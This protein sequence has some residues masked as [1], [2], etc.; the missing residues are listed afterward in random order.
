M[1]KKGGREVDKRWALWVICLLILPSFFFDEKHKYIEEKTT[2]ELKINK[3]R[4]PLSETTS[5]HKLSSLPPLF[6]LYTTFKQC[7]YNCFA[8]VTI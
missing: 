4:S 7:F 3:H 5:L 2:A 6:S 8:L 1:R